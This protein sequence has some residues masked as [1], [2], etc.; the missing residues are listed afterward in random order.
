MEYNVVTI[1][2]K[3]ANRANNIPSG[4]ASRAM[5]ALGNVSKTTRPTRSPAST[6]SRSDNTTMRSNP[7]LTTDAVSRR[8]GQRLS[9]PMT[10]APRSGIR[11]VNP[12]AADSLTATHSGH[13][14]PHSTCRHQ[15]PP[16]RLSAACLATPTLRPV[17]TPKNRLARINVHNGA[18]NDRGASRTGSVSA[19]TDWK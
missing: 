8:L 11:M 12:S 14:M 4:S 5:G 16:M 2:R 7:A 10:P 15:P 3:L 18:S 1:Q 19:G 17:L 9:I 13:G 6:E